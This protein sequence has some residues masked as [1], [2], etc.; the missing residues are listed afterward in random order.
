[1]TTL[2]RDL[3]EIPDR[4]LA[5]D[6]VL[7]L[8]KGVEE[9]STIDQYVV[10]EQLAGCF[11]RALGVIQTAVETS[12]SRAS[13]LDGSFGSGK[14]HFMAILYAILR[15]DPDARGK[16]GLAD[17][18]AKHDSWLRGR[19][20]LLIPYH[21]PDA[22]TLDSAILGGYVAHVQKLHP[23]AAL[24]A[25]YVDDELLDDAR[26]LRARLG[27][28]KFTAEL[29]AGDEEWGTPG[30]DSALLDAAFAAPPGDP[31]RR[32]L[33]GDLLTGPFHR[34]ARA[35]RGD[36]ES[37]I[38]LDLGLSVISAHAKQV[39]GYD[40]VV[41]LLDELVLWLAGYL[42]D[43]ARVS[44]EAQKVS[45]LVESAEHE[46]PAPIISF[47]PRQRDLRD[48]VGRDTPG[49][50]V[51]S[52]FD[53]LKYWDG[54]FDV[55]KLDDR[56]LP[57]IVHERLLRPKND[58]ARATLDEAFGRTASV[59]AEVWETLLDV[60]GEK[61][62]RDAFRATYPFSPAFLHAMVD[63]SG[64]LQ[65]ERTALKLMQQ[66]LVDYRDA[67]VVGQLMPIGAIFDVL[68]SGAD[69]PFTDK[70]RDE[71]DQA[72]RFYF[73]QVR[74]YLLE[75][76]G[77]TDQQA[78]GV[79]PQH[80]FRADDLIAKTLLLAALVPNVPALRGLTASRLAA[81]NHGSIVAMLPN[82]ERRTVAATLRYLARKFGEFRVSEDE[83]PR[84]DLAIIGIDTEGILR[85]ARYVDDAAA[86][87]RV[88]KDLLWEEMDVADKGELVTAINIVWRGTLRRV[89]L[90]F[91]NV[92]DEDSLPWQQFE[93]GQDGAI[94]VITDYPFDEGTHSPVEDANR[95]R[96]LPAQLDG[97]ATLAWLPHFL[98]TRRLDDLSDLIVISHVL[99]PGVLEDLTPNLTAEDRHHARLQLDSR[100]AALT[101]RLRDAIKRAYGVASPEEEDLGARTDTHVLSL[102]V[103]VEP[104]PQVGQ[105]LGTALRGLCY[106][107]L[108]HR[109]P[110]HPDFDPQGR[111]QAIKATE[112]TTVLRAVEEAAQDPVGR[113][114]PSRADTQIL[115]RIA[116]PLRLGVMHEAAFVLGDDW[117][118][119]LDRR[120][121]GRSEVTVTQLR[122][123]VDEEQP[124]MPEPVQD[125]V[126]ACYAVQA[127]R[128]WAR[129]GGP[130]MTAPELGAIRPE[131]VL[132][133]Q[134]LPSQSEFGQ[135]ARRAEGIFGAARQ[136]VRS[137]RASNA[138]TRDVRLRAGELLTAAEAL[139]EALEM[140][141]D[142]LGLDA[143][144]P[145]L[146]T[147]RVLSG[148]LNQ[149]AGTTDSTTL[150]R[151]LAAADLP[152]ENAIYRTHLE[153]ARKVTAGING[154]RWQVLDRLTKVTAGDEAAAAD[155]LLRELRSA[156]RH[157]EHEVGLAET[158]QR[159]EQ[160]A[161]A[162]FLDAASKRG[163]QQPG[164]DD[165]ETPQPGPAMEVRRASGAK[166]HEVV[167]EIRTAADAD[168]DR[169]FE[170]T[171]RVVT[172]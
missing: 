128:A 66:L 146:V 53:T 90:V 84:V 29:P 123:W 150:I 27:E 100:R 61:A 54:R 132:R 137:N 9:K 106:Q 2:L 139:T 14:S 145:R 11:D 22:T 151:A 15:G 55:I 149:L 114:E 120:V 122:G 50:V 81:L 79:G 171:W 144:S 56:N 33:V 105:G 28:E 78:A 163:E 60:H 125:L 25:V 40:A 119:H 20:F 172:E 5:G 134:E 141:A 1:M 21:L 102:D 48:L 167:E 8:S 13:Y 52:L 85:Q 36:A 157:D 135:A 158:L 44:R 92:R 147:A 111:R 170:I 121:A 152:R 71:F 82:Q 136:P 12:S 133:S 83:D 96:R 38:P 64:A 142:T 86:R 88:I 77:L 32:R 107:L 34:Y 17:V 148:L 93:P 109:Y 113:Y 101:T 140:H 4:V 103:G 3:I 69:R 126:I 112:L 70:L 24:P 159:V 75:K 138:I 130:V 16:K 127:D 87:R 162:L 95:V 26:E 19:K 110:R 59:R 49:A 104:R 63:I 18:V 43:Q 73:N 129:P 131:F 46:R 165:N 124:G 164:R 41:L 117:K 166:V 154:T 160:Q 80:V 155:T 10:T 97:A 67:L 31:E 45:K 35:V 118:Q 72:K 169:Q 108:D 42:G 37:Y 6:F 7:A 89:E 76:H 94:R 65:R 115:R 58:T 161:T 153:H 30:W 51:T 91:G 39:L 47:V 116:N 168:P 74:P 143:S 98:S 99:R 62:D 23:G 68:A 156:A 57:A